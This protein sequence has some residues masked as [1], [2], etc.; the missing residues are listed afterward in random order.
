MIDEDDD[1]LQRSA[2]LCITDWKEFY[3]IQ[4]VLA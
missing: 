4:L 2:D 3:E 1:Q